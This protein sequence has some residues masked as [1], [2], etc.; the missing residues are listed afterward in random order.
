MM[1]AHLQRFE[2]RRLRSEAKAKEAEEEEA[3]TGDMG[4]QAMRR[5]LI[6]SR[7]VRGTYLSAPFLVGGVGLERA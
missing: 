2:D 1:T 5:A 6:K 7:Q 4:T 3:A